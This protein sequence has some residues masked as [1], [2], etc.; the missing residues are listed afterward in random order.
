[1]YGT[2]LA[3]LH[4]VVTIGHAVTEPVVATVAPAAISEDVST[5]C[6]TI[7]APA[8]LTRAARLSD[9]DASRSLL[10]DEVEYRPRFGT[11]G[12]DLLVVDCC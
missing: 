8:T 6:G 5:R 10:R 4:G 3:E 2:W 7:S 11:D 1:V 9:L 12:N